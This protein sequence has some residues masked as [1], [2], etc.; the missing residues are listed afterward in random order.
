MKCSLIY[1]LLLCTLLLGGHPL[2]ATNT[3]KKVKLRVTLHG[4]KTY[5]GRLEWK[6]THLLIRGGRKRKIDYQDISSITAAT[7]PDEEA[8]RKQFAARKTARP[9]ENAKAWLRLARWARKQGL[10]DEAAEACAEAAK[11]EPDN[12]AARQGSGQFK[13]PEKGWIPVGVV[14]GQRRGKLKAEDHDG[15]VDLA[16]FARKH[17]STQFAFDLCTQ[18]LLEDAFHADALR[19]IRTATDRYQQATKLRLPIAGRWEISADRTRHHQKKGYAVYAVDLTKVDEDRKHYT[20]RGKRLEDHFA[21]DQPFYAVADGTVVEVREGFRDN[22]IGKIGDQAEKHNGVAIDHGQG[23][24]SWY[25]HAKKG[26]ITVKLG[27]KVKR[28]ELL[29]TV[30]NSGGSAIPHLHFTLVSFRGLS[31]PWRCEEFEVMAPTGSAIRAL[32]VWPREGWV[33]LGKEPGK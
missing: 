16:R 28:G 26:S 21:W 25:V 30:G 10:H 15:R 20:G 11:L 32:D 2:H 12:V 18:V 24:L 5:T 31:V 1:W 33:V 17:G 8:L 19:V 23:E 27:Q 7:S 29:G 6:K 13:D 9:P 4:G 14:L 22:P 3:G